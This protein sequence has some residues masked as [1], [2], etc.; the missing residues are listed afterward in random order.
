VKKLKNIL[1][2]VVIL[3]ISFV[4]ILIMFLNSTFGNYAVIVYDL[5]IN[6]ILFF[7]YIALT[8]V[9]IVWIKK[10]LRKDYYYL[11]SIPIIFVLISFIWRQN[12]HKNVVLEALIEDSKGSSLTL[13]DNNT[14]EIKLQHQHL[15]YF[16]KG[17][18]KKEGIEI[19]LKENDIVD[20]TDSL[21]TQRY[22]ILKN[23]V[24]EPIDNEKFKTITVYNTVYN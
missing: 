7:V 5:L 10:H 20:L 22:R 11:F 16:K 8:L 21:F 18:Y 3:S 4:G 12:L 15:A 1:N 19:Y 9:F 6:P 24:L 23:A 2:I 17:N 13:F 14:F